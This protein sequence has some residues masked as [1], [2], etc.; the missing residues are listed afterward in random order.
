ML[1]KRRQKAISIAFHVICLVCELKTCPDSD[2][3]KAVGSR[4]MYAYKG[5]HIYKDSC[6]CYSNTS[7]QAVNGPSR[8]IVHPLQVWLV[9]R[10]G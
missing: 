9:Q 5:V 7:Q 3:P 4:A 6:R 1:Y 2:Q 8:P 10:N